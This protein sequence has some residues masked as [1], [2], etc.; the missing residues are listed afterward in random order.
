MNEFY[1]S[2][3][4]GL[5]GNEDCGQMSAWYAFSAIGLYPVL[6]GNNQYILGSPLFDKITIHQENGKDF[7]ITAVNNS[8]QNKYVNALKL[9]GKDH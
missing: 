4:D 1:H 5:C 9:N 2:G 7:V 8:G 3:R 6:P